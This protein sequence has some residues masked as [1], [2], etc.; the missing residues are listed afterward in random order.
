MDPRF[1]G[2]RG[3]AALTLTAG[4]DRPSHEVVRFLLDRGVDINATDSDGRTALDWA[5]T[6]GETDTSA[7]AATR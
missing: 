6:R 1:V 5:L 3:T 2:A 4:A 7:G